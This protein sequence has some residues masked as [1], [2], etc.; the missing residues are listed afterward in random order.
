MKDFIKKHK[1]LVICVPVIIL[2]C[3]ISILGV[4]AYNR[5]QEIKSLIR[6]GN[7]YLAGADYEQAIAVYRQTLRIDERN[8]EARMGMAEC[9]RATG[10]TE[11]AVEEYY[12]VISEKPK[13]PDPYVRL[14]EIFL[15]DGESEKARDIIE[16]GKNNAKNDETIN[17]LWDMTH[18]AAPTVDP[19]PGR[20]SERQVVTLSAEGSNRIYYTTDG[21]DPRENGL[22]YDAKLILRNGE[23]NIR[24]V[25]FNYSGFYSD[26]AE[27]NYQID[28]EDEKIKL[29][30][31]IISSII[32]DNIVT[33]S[34]KEPDDGSVNNDELAQVTSLYIIG[35]NYFAVNNDSELIITDGYC[36]IGGRSFQMV[37]NGYVRSLSDI[38]N[39]PYLETLV[40]ASQ[41]N[42]DLSD[43]NPPAS[44]KKLSLINNNITSASLKLIAK[45]TSLEQLCL[46]F[47]MIDDISALS[48]MTSLKSLG[49]WG[50]KIKDLSPLKSLKS[51]EYLDFSDNSV[52]DIS[53][54]SEFT[55]LKELW[56]YEN[57]I[58]KI[59][60]VSGLDTLEVLM[61][62]D[63]PISD[64]ESV[65]AI[66][67]R[68]KNI[69]VDLL[70]L[71]E[72]E[73]SGK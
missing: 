2:I 3:V 60:A 14:A 34:D 64:P 49:L 17:E 57:K 68:L 11:Y 59:S 9:Y 67:P 51:L 30:D 73:D 40:V 32:R 48:G 21:T 56:M 41:K 28:I 16:D 47:N 1:L 58:Q 10:K 27:F 13:Y 20:Y 61:L 23:T 43:F 54:V 8:I 70:G 63:N 72:K 7:R 45:A 12:A 42:L 44:L 19:A 39:M 26:T 25:A 38:A 18:P 33:P 69:D 24:A 62:A 52:S 15:G 4:M 35:N 36:S 37:Q 71:G 29:D 66:Y 55:M 50:N 5:G 53:V 65:R 22:E 31:D 46:G 6:E